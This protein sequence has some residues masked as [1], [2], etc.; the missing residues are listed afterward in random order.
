MEDQCQ[1][2]NQWSSSA[3]LQSHRACR[4]SKDVTL[5]L[6]DV[7]VLSSPLV[8]LTVLRILLSTP[9][10]V[11]SYFLIWYVPPFENGKVIWYL[12]FYCLF[13]SLQT[14]S[15]TLMQMWTSAASIC[16]IHTKWFALLSELLIRKALNSYT[17]YIEFTVNNYFIIIQYTIHNYLKHH[18]L[19]ILELVKDLTGALSPPCGRNLWVTY[20]ISGVFCW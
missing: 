16:A 14:V 3:C 12:F 13:Q 8:L 18:H 11:L 4:L 6:T 9:L 1:L 7:F 20:S 19:C 15:T 5:S 17:V 10:A 2:C